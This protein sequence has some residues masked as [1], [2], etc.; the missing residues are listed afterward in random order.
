MCMCIYHL[1]HTVSVLEDVLEEN[2]SFFLGK[3]RES[4]WKGDEFVTKNDI[5]C[6]YTTYIWC[7]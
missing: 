5:L 6:V 7:V 1:T 2:L 3:W 4:G